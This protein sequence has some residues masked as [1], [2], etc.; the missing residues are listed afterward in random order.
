MMRVAVCDDEKRIREEIA[1]RIR[2]SLPDCEIDVYGSGK[3]LL[4]ALRER[5]FDLLL[6]DIDMPEKS[7]LELASQIM[8]GT[9]RPLIVFVTSHDEP[10]YD[11]L[12]LHPFGFVRKSHLDDELTRVLRD[13]AE[14]VCARDRHFCFHTS[15]GDVRL[16][17]E[18]IL[19]F[20]SDG[21]YIKVKT[22][23]AEY[24]FRETMQVLENTLVQDGFVRVHK[25]F[26]VNQEAVKIINS[27]MI[28]LTDN[29]EIPL[30]R[31]YQEN[32]RRTLMRSMLR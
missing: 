11:S 30:G 28:I 25:G 5:T 21:N 2:E 7:G 12:Q 18:D 23:D 1:G 20:E 8:S 26:L 31:S 17:T 3:E 15:S 22:V 27:D 16:K 9:E 6:L 14:E 13:A 10:V 19:Y 4:K 24:R 29:S 32:A